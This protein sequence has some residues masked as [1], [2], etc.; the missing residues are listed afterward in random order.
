MNQSPHKKGTL[1][2]LCGLDEKTQS[3]INHD[4]LEV[5]KKYCKS[6]YVPVVKLLNSQVGVIIA[7]I[8]GIA[9]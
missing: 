7:D 5:S 2:Y 3:F 4:I 6:C 8:A 1:L 9:Y